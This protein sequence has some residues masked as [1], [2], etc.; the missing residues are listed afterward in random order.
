M[1]PITM[2]IVQGNGRQPD[3]QSKELPPEGKWPLITA[4]TKQMPETQTPQSLGRLT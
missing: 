2:R 3:G 1:L 4:H